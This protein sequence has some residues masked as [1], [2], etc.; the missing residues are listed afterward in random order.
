MPSQ[1][2]HVYKE[3]PHYNTGS[4][5]LSDINTVWKPFA[6]LHTLGWQVLMISGLM[7]DKGKWALLTYREGF[8]H[9]SFSAWA[10]ALAAVCLRNRAER[11]SRTIGDV[12]VV[13]K[14]CSS[15]VP[16]KDHTT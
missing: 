11:G 10:I 6:L 1:V 16:A 13:R 3:V 5:I 14:I 9:T 12:K 4:I 8:G 15:C 2:Q 7:M